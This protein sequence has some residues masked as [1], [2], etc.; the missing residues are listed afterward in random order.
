MDEF[1][2]L[3]KN[4]KHAAYGELVHMLSLPVTYTLYRYRYEHGAA[5]AGLFPE[6]IQVFPVFTNMLQSLERHNQLDGVVRD[7]IHGLIILKAISTLILFTQ[8][9]G[10]GKVQ[11]GLTV[12]DEDEAFVLKVIGDQF[13]VSSQSAPKIEDGI[14]P[15]KQG[16]EFLREF[17]I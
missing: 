9:R 17:G 2:I 4:L 13:Q 7:L 1:S 6:S 11:G 15:F 16:P 12:I 10:P 3:G 8:Q 14:G 5:G